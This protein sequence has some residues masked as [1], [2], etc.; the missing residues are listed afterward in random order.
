MRSP[1]G[2]TR[3]LVAVLLLVVFGA[4]S[5]VGGRTE[6]FRQPA[7]EEP[8]GLT[9]GRDVYMRDCAWC[10]GSEGEGTTRGPDLTSGTNGEAFTHFM[11]TT[12]R[13][14]IN[15]PT[16]PVMRRDPIYAEGEIEDVVAFVASLDGEGPTIPEVD[17]D[18]GDLSLGFR[19]YQENCA[20][21]HSTTGIGGALTTGRAGALEGAVAERSGIIAPAIDEASPT[22]IAEAMAV[23]PGAM[24]VFG[25]ET[26]EDREV[27]AIVR[28][29]EYLQDPA[30]RGG[31]DLGG[32]GTVTE[33]AVALIVGL[34]A[35]LL[36]I[37]CIGTTRRE[38]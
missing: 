32:I 37:R 6:P 12:G 16:D 23:G 10:H 28:Y 15:E 29:V 2:P 18:I 3:R 25:D 14:P 30:D 35:L 36:L 17:T 13:M 38:E 24:P 33:G 19:L 27:D 22:E 7:R 11:L 21:C 20:A 5:Y 1:P 4:C 34:G 31:A 26:F 9:R 8:S